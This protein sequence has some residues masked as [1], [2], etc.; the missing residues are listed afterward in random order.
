VTTL[1]TPLEDA[2]GS[3]DDPIVRNIRAVALLSKRAALQRST[4]ALVC[5]RVTY[6]VG[7]TASLILHALWFA[8][9][10]TVNALLPTPF[11]PFPFSLLTSLV[12]LEAIF[13]SLFVLNSQNRLTQDSDQRAQIDL[14]VN[15][16][17]EQEM[18]LVLRML[19]DLCARSD[20]AVPEGLTELL[21]DV[22]LEKVAETVAKELPAQS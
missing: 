15:L 3:A 2:A 8:G 20:I 1:S 16:L 21:R 5:D 22:D 17:A 9:W 12:S 14:Q 7:T 13:L 11:D 4:F 10:I 6:S 19:R 18:T